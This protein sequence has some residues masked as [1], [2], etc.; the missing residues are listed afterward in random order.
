[1]PMLV[2]FEVLETHMMM[3]F[4]YVFPNLKIISKRFLLK[5]EISSYDHNK[6]MAYIS[7]IS[8][9]YALKM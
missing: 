5:L 4:C 6:T 1:M 2:V 8:R 7:N 3:R 9:F